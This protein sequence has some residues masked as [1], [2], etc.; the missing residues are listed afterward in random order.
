[1][2]NL[3]STGKIASLLISYRY[4]IFFPI[5]IVEGP[6]ATLIA[7]FLVSLG[8]FNIF[9]VYGVAVVGDLVGDMIYYV[10]GSAGGEQILKRGRFLGIKT[11]QL[12]KLQEHFKAHAGKT[13]LFGKWTHAVGGAILLAGGIARMSFKKFI[14]FNFLGTLPKALVFLIIGYYFGQAYQ[15]IDK[16]FGYATLSIFLAIVLAAAIYFFA[17]RMRQSLKI[18]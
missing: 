10:I 6:I 9:A 14:W 1:M 11:E 2:F 4:A 3:I 13:L 17:K 18:D 15:Q 5:T 16:Y 8:Y 12:T 7:G